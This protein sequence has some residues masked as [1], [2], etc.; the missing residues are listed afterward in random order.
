MDVN[1]GGPMNSNDSRLES[2]QVKW[3]ADELPNGTFQP[4]IEF[5]GLAKFT[6]NLVFP[7]NEVAFRFVSLAFG[8][9]TGP[10]PNLQIDPEGNIE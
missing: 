5:E 4:F 7:T 3:G 8:I 1:T 9:L 2:P 10:K 6:C